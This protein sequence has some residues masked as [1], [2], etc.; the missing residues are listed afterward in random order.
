[1]LVRPASDPC[2]G[3]FFDASYLAFDQGSGGFEVLVAVGLVGGE[4]AEFLVRDFR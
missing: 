4:V 2:I 1:M 3:G